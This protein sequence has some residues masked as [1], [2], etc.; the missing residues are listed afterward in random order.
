MLMNMGQTE[1]FILDMPSYMLEHTS[2]DLMMLAKVTTFEQ[3]LACLAGTP[4]AP[5]LRKVRKEEQKTDYLRC[6]SVLYDFYY[7]YLLQSVDKHFRGEARKNLRDI[8][9]S[10]IEAHNM[11]IIFRLKR[12]YKMEADKIKPLLFHFSLN[13]DKIEKLF[14]ADTIEEMVKVS[15]IHWTQPQGKTIP[16]GFVE[17]V[18]HSFCYDVYKKRMHFTTQAP[19]AMYTFLALRNIEVQNIITVI[20]GVRYGQPQ[21]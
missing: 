11:E 21:N 20:E 7:T 16:E 9:M 3:L 18:T 8:M 1:D 10:E 13:E 19:V 5:I 14:A 6:E 17:L 12:F 15:G 4:Y 2:F